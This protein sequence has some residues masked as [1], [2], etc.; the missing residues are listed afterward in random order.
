MTTEKTQRLT[1]RIS[2]RS[3]LFSTTDGRGVT[4]ERYPLKS[5]I[6][7]AANLREALQQSPMLQEKYL[8]AYVMMDTPVLTIPVDLFNEKDSETLY[9]HTFTLQ[10]Q[11]TV[12]H[13]VLPELNAVAVFPI[14]KDLLQVITEH[15]GQVTVMPVT[16]PVWRHTH[17]K[18]FTGPR[19][20]LYAYFHDRRMEVFCFTQNRFKFNN[21]FAVNNPNDAV[22]YLLSV[23]KQLAMV[24]EEDE[25]HLAGML[26]EKEAL[27]EL[28]RQFIKRVFV[29]N[30]SG[31]FNRS[32]VTQIEGMP[33]DMMLHYLRH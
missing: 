1:I 24:P 20:K 16:A 23:W 11:Q 12:M 8:R 18:S 14:Q 3:M 4:L 2:S 5:G 33:Y 31:E 30:P 27:T 7:L 29:N 15:F 32:A 6:S 28:I 22:Y 13:A 25:L 10:G 21:S 19:T 26:P 17:K 9:R